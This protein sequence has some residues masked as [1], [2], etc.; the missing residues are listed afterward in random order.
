MIFLIYTDFYSKESEGEIM[1][2]T[3]KRFLIIFFLLVNSIFAFASPFNTNL[4]DSDKQ[5]IKDGKILIKKIDYTK[6]MGINSGINDFGDK[7]INSY[8]SL[9]PKYL[10][11]IIQI[12]P[13]E[14]NEDLPEKMKTLLENVSDY[15]GIPYY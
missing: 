8:K 2:K 15:A 11:E 14:G 1:I 4:S 10:A 6:N 3:A 12:K 5:T 13:I 7:L 9:S